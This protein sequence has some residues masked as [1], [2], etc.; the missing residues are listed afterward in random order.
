MDAILGTLSHYG[1][2]VSEAGYKE[3]AKTNY[4][5]SIALEWAESWKGTGQFSGFPL[6]ASEELWKRL[7]PDRLAPWLLGERVGELVQQLDRMVDGAPDAKVGPAFEAVN[8]LKPKIPME[9]GGAQRQFVAEAFDVFSEQFIRAFDGLAEKL[10]KEGHVEDAQAF[11]EL[12]ELLF[13]ER[14]EVA[15]AIVQAADGHWDV[16]EKMLI[17]RVQTPSLSDGAQ[18]VAVDGLIHIH[19]KA[20]EEHA[21]RL[22]DAAEKA[23]NHHLALAMVDRL[24]HLYRESHNR[25]ALEALAARAEKLVAAHN[26]AHPNH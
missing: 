26:K 25:G 4:P 15:R 5:L 3:L 1:V 14:A 18:V 10:A 24:A 9:N 2:S 8:A 16:A 23:E 20:A 21:A 11:A 19:S 13:P 6:A 12:E 17:A 7:E 22:L